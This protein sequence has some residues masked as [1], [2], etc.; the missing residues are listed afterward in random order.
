MARILIAWELGEAFGHLAR[1]LRLAQGLR[2]RGHTIVL[3][4][5]PLLMRP[6]HVA[7]AI[8]RTLTFIEQMFLEPWGTERISHAQ[9]SKE[10]TQACLH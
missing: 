8:E 3:A 2:Q 9:K 10:K 4:G 1:C 5:V 6:R 7:Q